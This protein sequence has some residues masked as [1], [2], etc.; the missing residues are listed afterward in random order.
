MLGPVIALTVMQAP[1]AW[2]Y[3]AITTVLLGFP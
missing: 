1:T 3:F 2:E